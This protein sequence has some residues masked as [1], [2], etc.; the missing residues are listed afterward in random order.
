VIEAVLAFLYSP[1]GKVLLAQR[2]EGKSYGGF[3]LS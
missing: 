2:P 3:K 1:E